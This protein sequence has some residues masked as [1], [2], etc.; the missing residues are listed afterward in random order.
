MVPGLIN[1]DFAD[2][3]SVMSGMGRAMMGIGAGEGQDR[4]LE[5][6]QNAISNPLLEQESLAGASAVLVNITGGRD[7]TLLEVDQ[8]AAAVA[9]QVD[10]DANIFFGAV[11]DETMQGKI[12]VSVVATGMAGADAAG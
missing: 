2:V 11:L 1:L 12:R 3:L 6:V 5:A 9:D 10:P 8:A 7:L 4:A